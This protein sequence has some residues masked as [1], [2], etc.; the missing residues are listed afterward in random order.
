MG[1][2]DQ[3]LESPSNGGVQKF[4]LGSRFAVPRG[5]DK[6]QH[7]RQTPPLHPQRFAR[8]SSRRSIDEETASMSASERSRW[9]D[10]SSERT[11]STL[12]SLSERSRATTHRVRFE[13][14]KN[15][16][17]ITHSRKANYR[18]RKSDYRKLWWT[19]EEAKRTSEKITNLIK[20]Y[21]EHE[22]YVHEFIHVFTM[23][24]RFDERL[25]IDIDDEMLKFLQSP[26]RGLEVQILAILDRYR[27]KH[28]ASILEA[29]DDV[30]DYVDPLV[31]ER[32]LSDQ[33]LVYSRVGR[34]FARL[35]AVSDSDTIA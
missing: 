6:A 18:L 35:L 11:R 33:S 7:L 3:L 26:A 12:C 19:N 31:R 8:S 34:V 23:C 1:I 14:T 20:T 13:T 25:P 24:A 9:T 21:E 16:E 17:I 15:D 4:H 27:T 29:Q 22:E 28:V 10:I 30:P 5:V 2:R 32:I